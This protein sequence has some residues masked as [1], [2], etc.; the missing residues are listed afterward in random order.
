MEN[1]INDLIENKENDIINRI[2]SY[3]DEIENKQSNYFESI[4]KELFDLY[5]SFKNDID[6]E[7]LN[8]MSDKLFHIENSLAQL[9]ENNKIVSS[10]IDNDKKE[11]SDSFN[12]LSKEFEIFKSSINIANANEKIN[13]TNENS[14]SS[15]LNEYVE[16]IA[17]LK[18]ALENIKDDINN[19]NKEFNDR[20]EKRIAFFEDSWSDKEN[21]KRLFSDLTND[22]FKSLKEKLESKL[23]LS[24]EEALEQSLKEYK[25]KITKW[26]KI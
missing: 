12:N 25:E 16:K 4:R 19:N 20:I 14:A 3:E 22:K 24:I 23:N 15:L 8:Y 21:I 6:I 7:S 9:E 1:R 13:D 10:K 18:N 17:T 5:D 26:K 2:N 11:L